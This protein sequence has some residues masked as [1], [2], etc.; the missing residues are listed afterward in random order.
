MLI[1]NYKNQFTIYLSDIDYKKLKFTNY[2]VGDVIIEIDNVPI[3]DKNIFKE[4]N[5]LE[6][7]ELKDSTTQFGFNNLLDKEQ[8]IP[9]N[10]IHITGIDEFAKV[11][12][13]EEDRMILNKSIMENKE[14]EEK[15]ITWSP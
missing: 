14:L 1:G 8:F 11:M 3:T 15:I 9:E 12:I 2:P 13:R 10:K 4:F 6:R 7:R 5:L